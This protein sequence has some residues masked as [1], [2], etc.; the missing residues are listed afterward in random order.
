MIK[1]DFNNGW[2]YAHLGADYFKEV[3]LPHDAMFSE[4]RG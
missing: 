1:I 4:P 3:T 2:K